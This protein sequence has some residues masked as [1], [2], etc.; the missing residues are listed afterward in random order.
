MAFLSQEAASISFSDI[1]FDSLPLKLVDIDIPRESIF[2]FFH[3]EPWTKQWKSILLGSLFHILRVD[4]SFHNLCR[5]G[6]L[7]GVMEYVDSGIDI[8]V[9]FSIQMLIRRCWMT[10]NELDFIG[11]LRRKIQS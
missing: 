7:E 8:N 10:M 9:V 5:I 2:L 3:Q 11:L 6:D 4:K 1:P